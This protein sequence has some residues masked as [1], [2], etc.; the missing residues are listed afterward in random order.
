MAFAAVRIRGTVLAR[1]E[2]VDTLKM[3]RLTRTNHCVILPENPST[4]GMLLK[5]QDYVTWGEVT[6]QTVARLLLKRGQAPGHYAL[7][8]A[9][10]KANSKF[11][12]IW[13]FTQALA[14]GE[15]TPKDIKGLNPVLRLSPPIKG[16]K[17]VKLPYAAGGDLGYRGKEIDNLLT[18]MIGGEK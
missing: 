11:S 14:K 7:N 13:D 9:Y 1:Q 16:Y 2:V 4:K 18:R 3:L 10:V 6:P 5:V 17:S 12:S 15:A 8:D